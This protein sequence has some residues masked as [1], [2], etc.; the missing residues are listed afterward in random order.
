MFALTLSSGVYV[1][2][3]NRKLSGT[4]IDARYLL[5]AIALMAIATVI[6]ITD[7]TRVICAPHSLVQGHA[8]WHILGAI[9]AWLLFRYYRTETGGV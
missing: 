5:L 4:R 3:R 9:S 2:Y 8:I 7:I 1:E 6:W